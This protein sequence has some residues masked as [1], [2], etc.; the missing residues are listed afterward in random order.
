[1]NSQKTILLKT[2]TLHFSQGTHNATM[3]YPQ[4]LRS[5]RKCLFRHYQKE[6]KYQ[7]VYIL[8]ANELALE[9]GGQILTIHFGSHHYP[10]LIVTEACRSF[11]TIL[12]ESEYK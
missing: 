6:W 8:Q 9:K 10:I 3:R 1:M 2:G 4:L 12:F 7:P 5:F 11:T